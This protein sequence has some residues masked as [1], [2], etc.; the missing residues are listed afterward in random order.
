MATSAVRGL[1]EK[2]HLAT[3]HMGN[4]GQLHIAEMALVLMEGLRG[5]RLS[6][7]TARM[8]KRLV[9]HHRGQRDARSD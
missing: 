2:P 1:R 6:Q 9:A 4:G 5:D 8:A 7:G 3:V